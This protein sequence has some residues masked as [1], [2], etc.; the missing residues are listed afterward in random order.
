MFMCLSS[1]NLSKVTVNAQSDRQE[2][3]FISWLNCF[4]CD[5]TQTGCKCFRHRH[6]VTHICSRWYLLHLLLPTPLPPPSPPTPAKVGPCVYEWCDV[7]QFFTVPPPYIHKL[8]PPISQTHTP[9]QTKTGAPTTHH[10]SLS[11]LYETSQVRATELHGWPCFECALRLLS[12]REILCSLRI[13]LIMNEWLKRV[14][15][16]ILGSFYLAEFLEYQ[17]ARL[18]PSW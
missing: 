4:L 3:N 12:G 13:L 7:V 6:T 2:I 11:S 1:F 18:F 14:Y 10:R 8:S 16:V 9:Q 15:C 5:K 17:G